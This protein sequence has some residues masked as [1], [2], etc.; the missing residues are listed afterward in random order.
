MISYLDV[1]IVLY[2]IDNHSNVI[3]KSET[4]KRERVWSGVW[5]ILNN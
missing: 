1:T 4:N 5:K 2:I 3:K